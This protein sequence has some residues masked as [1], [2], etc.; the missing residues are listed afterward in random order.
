MLTPLLHMGT[1]F[2]ALLLAVYLCLV[3]ML[4]ASN[5]LIAVLVVGLLMVLLYATSQW[6]I[7]TLRYQWP[8]VAL[9]GLLVLGLAITGVMNTVAAHRVDAGGLS[10]HLC[11]ANNQVDSCQQ[12]FQ[13][14]WGSVPL[15]FGPKAKRLPAS[16]LGVA[17]YGVLLLWFLIVGR[18]DPSRGLWHAVP[19]LLTFSATAV[20]VGMAY[21]LFTKFPAPCGLCLAS[22]GVTGLLFIGSV[23][24]WPRR[25][26]AARASLEGATERTEEPTAMANVRARQRA[27]VAVAFGLAAAVMGMLAR[28]TTGY[29]QSAQRIERAYKEIID[30]PAFVR[31]DWSRQEEFDWEVRDDDSMRGAPQAPFIAITYSDFQCPFC[32]KLS[33]RLEKLCEEYP[34]RIRWIYRHYPLARACNPH[35]KS[36]S[37]PFSCAAARAAEAARLVGGDEAFWKMHDALYGEGVRLVERPYVRL[38]K[39]IGL[40]EEA[41]RKAMADPASLRRIQAHIQAGAELDIQGTPTI[42]LNGKLLRRG[43]WNSDA[44][45][46]SLLNPSTSGPASRPAGSTTRQSTT[47]GSGG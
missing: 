12:A 47:D 20:A 4:G 46:E 42:L 45:W 23:L 25:G 33:L 34:G 7:G 13:S 3:A 10:Q 24:A 32:R 36:S 26:A 1:Y 37:H 39:E 11:R 38:A 27:M 18:P 43:G 40:D 17:F 5:V 41:F 6:L 9:L 44:L 16:M 22:H 35:S 21:L 15:G 19:V 2:L 14:P 31:W 30:D 8:V 29:Q 28:A